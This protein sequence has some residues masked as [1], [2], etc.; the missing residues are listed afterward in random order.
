MGAE[1]LE[2]MPRLLLERGVEVLDARSA[3]THKGVR[4]AAK[5]AIAAGCR[6]IVVC[7]GDGTHCGIVRY[8]AHRK[9]A[10][11]VVPAGTGNSFALG[12]GID[13]FER[14]ADAVAYGSERCIDAGRIDDTYF[15]NFVTIGLAAEIAH[16]SSHALKRIVGPIAY[17]AASLVPMFRHEP[18]AASLRWKHKRVDVE[19]HQIIV[20][21][22]RFFGHEPLAPQASLTNG[23]LT[24]FVREAG[25]KID[26]MATYVALLRGEQCELDG[27]RLWSTSAKLEIRTK[28]KVAVSA[29]GNEFGKTPV[30]LCVEPRALRVMVPPPVEAARDS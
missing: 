3:E 29:D 10:L 24:V 9:C 18:F 23:R 4:K 2:T 30:R 19:T 12:L 5:R 6:L 26:L 11:G 13:S 20:A 14:A 25:S 7:G 21:N 16:S 8:L 28:P 15:A 17:G 1:A 22:G 27:V